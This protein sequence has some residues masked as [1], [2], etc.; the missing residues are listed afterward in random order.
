MSIKH[1][2]PKR[3]RYTIGYILLLFILL[4]LLRAIWKT[5]PLR[6]P[7]YT[8]PD[9]EEII[10]SWSKVIYE[11]PDYTKP[12]KGPGENG[13]GVH[14]KGAEAKLS[15]QQVEGSPF[16]SVIA[17]DKISYDRSLKDP[18]SIA[19]KNVYYNTEELQTAS[20]IIVFTDEPFSS[21]VRT[22]HSV[23]NRS[24]K[25]LLKEVILVDDFSSNTDLQENLENHLSRFRGLEPLLDRITENPTSVVCPV[26]DG[27]SADNL[28]YLGGSAGG[29]GGFWW[30]LHYKME[31]IPES[32]KQRRKNPDVDFLRS[33]TMAGGLFAAN[34]HYFFEIGGYDEGMEIWGGE[35]LEIS[36]RVWMCGGSIEII[37]CSHVG[38]IF[39]AGHPYNMTS[40]LGEPDVHGFNSKRLADVWMD[41]YKRMYYRHRTN[42]EFADAGN[43]TER[44]NLRKRLKCK[45]F[46]WYLDNITPY[47]FIPDENV[48]AYGTVKNLQ[49][50]LCLDTLQR[51]EN[52]GTVILGIFA[53]QG[54]KGSEAQFFSLSK[55]DELR[56]ETTC[57]DVQGSREQKAVLRECSKKHS[58]FKVEDKRFVHVRTGLC[59]DATGLE[60]GNDLFFA[61]CNASNMA[62]Q[63]VFEKYLEHV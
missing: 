47:M 53:C 14:L 49:S 29:V 59:L 43:L 44:H 63:W 62:Q 21:L 55:D 36:F 18:R 41:D 31:V 52:K 1:W 22:V 42:L 32:E 24:P 45:S 6:R 35:N 5:F 39:R 9:I 16:M 37:P 27:I 57:V 51:N 25:N 19:C 34:R 26:I 33:P 60:S 48:K 17:S 61:P 54:G 2:I 28:E 56:R 30:S 12:R 38:H 4:F 40:T 50:E 11:Y 10:L 3:N 8:H 20:V 23:V 15:V 13:K 46:K 58:K 7:L